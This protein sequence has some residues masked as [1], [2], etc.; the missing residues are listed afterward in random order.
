M[1]IGKEYLISP[2]CDNFYF[3]LP[4]GALKNVTM[5]LRHSLT[6]VYDVEEAW[7]DCWPVGG[8]VWSGTPDCANTTPPKFGRAWE[9]PW[10]GTP[11][12]ANTTPSRFGR[13]WDVPWSWTPGCANTTPPRFGRAWDVPRSW[14]PGC[15]NTTP[16]RFGRAWEVPN[17]ICLACRLGNWIWPKSIPP[18]SPPRLSSRFAS[19]LNPPSQLKPY[20]IGVKFKSQVYGFAIRYAKQKKF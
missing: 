2:A 9:F 11:G 5:V 12:C 3:F 4:V 16:S 7:T 19:M 20:D 14:T 15:A 10:S 8:A 18:V 6:L 17:S 13:A 1:N